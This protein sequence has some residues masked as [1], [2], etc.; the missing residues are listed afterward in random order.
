MADY[1]AKINL[2]VQGQ[3]QINEL[4][5]Q[6]KV[7]TKELK[8]IKNLD[9]K[10]VFEDPLSGAALSKIRSEQEKLVTATKN[11]VREQEKVNKSTEKQLLNQIQLNA[12]VDLYE[13]KLKQVQQGNAQT[14]EQFA[15][16][17]EEIG[18]AFS[19]FKGKE[20]VSGVRAVATELGRIVEH[21]NLILSTQKQ[22]EA[23]QVR[24]KGYADELNT[25]SQAG[26]DISKAKVQLDKMETVTGTNKI[27][28]AT[29]YEGRL[30]EQLNILRQQSIEAKKVAKAEADKAK[31]ASKTRT[32][33]LSGVALGAGFPLLFGGGPGAVL[34]GAAGGLVGG[35]AGFA[36]QIALSA[37][38]Q[39]FDKLGSA[40][41]TLG[42]ALNPLTF[43]LSAV[44]KAAGIAG[45][46][47]ET[48]LAQIEQ[49]GG[50]TAA[51]EAATALLAN[52]IGKDATDALTKFGKEAQNVGNQISIIFTKVLAAIAAAAGPLLSA[53]GSSLER[54]NASGAFRGRKGLT[55]EEAIAQQI[56]Q[57]IVTRKGGKG[58]GAA[59]IKELGRQL[60]VE[61]S[62]RDIISKAR[63][64]AV[65][66]TRE[67]DAAN[68]AALELQATQLK[69]AQE[70]EKS[71]S[72]LNDELAK[73]KIKYTELL[74]IS[75]LDLQILRETDPIKRLQ[76]EQDKEIQEVY[77]KY[78]K[79]L[80]QAKGTEA[81]QLIL[82]TQANEIAGIRLETER[83][84]TDEYLKQFD[85]I[86]KFDPKLYKELV[87]LDGK[88]VTDVAFSSGI[89]LDSSGRAE[90]KLDDMNKK[91][92]DLSDPINM[93]ERGARSI[94]DAFNNAF[95]DI[96]TGAA[97]AQE[98]L[99][100]FFA[101]V[102]RAFTQMAA[103]IIAEMVTMY[104]FQQLLG[105]FGAASGSLF[106]GAGPVSGSS[107]A[108]VTFN[109]SSFSMGSLV[110]NADGSYVSS[111]TPALVGE[112]GADEYVIPANKMDSAMSR[113]NAGARGDSVVTGADPTGGMGG[114]AV[115]EAPSQ[116]NIS[117]GVFQYND[118]SY[119]RQDQI[120]S[121]V[122]QASKQGE[123]RALRRLQMSPSTR[124]K[125]GI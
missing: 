88:P 16:R 13:R 73:L 93:A 96:F 87:R 121:I 6:L 48:F 47:T 25:F 66:S 70:R 78:A 46:E 103:D 20:S 45:T 44:S 102:G 11:T 89:D 72:K 38:G 112:G 24:F 97:S 61:G 42:L 26:L 41:I 50:K 58:A 98:V 31:A 39:Q 64:I 57:K 36:A 77:N 79:D 23:I 2:I 85:A 43:D 111:P 105:I 19:F 84:I 67:F 65:K 15:G 82:K 14:Q 108:G 86:S 30:K 113:W 74:T 56:L 116:I 83:A 59:E 109:P 71:A 101:E 80:E 123:A 40:A 115:A 117:G 32:Q 106:S 37:I 53:L 29:I 90:Q 119:I 125:V 75:Q 63:D 114:T 34:G 76:L 99:S 51:A 9:I 7:I 8:N 95:M 60:G 92:K 10:G 12:A 54:L 94:G 68:S 122:S 91:L 28:Q 27:K 18:K 81:E 49:Y 55:G 4:E 3:S 104:A 118:T 5:K 33:R 124:R 17:I 21:E 110:P 52:R 62:T 120:P 107:A 1:S 69:S 22:R 100:N 35:P